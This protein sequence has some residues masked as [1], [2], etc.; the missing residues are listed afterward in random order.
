[1]ILRSA[2]LAL[3]IMALSISCVIFRPEIEI[4]LA[5][6]IPTAK[7]DFPSIIMLGDSHTSF[8]NWPIVLRCRGV[9]NFGIGGNTTAQILERLPDALAKRPRLII[10]MAG[11]NDAIQDLPEN[12]TLANLQTISAKVTQAGGKFVFVNPPPL[13]AN[14]EKIATIAQ[15]AT[16]SI[17]FTSD[18]LLSDGIHLRRSGYLKWRDAIWDVAQDNCN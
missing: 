1:M 11:T 18:D 14:P 10:L 9:A 2:G 4:W 12:E 6:K 8:V 17:P 3:A 15:G 7:P 16:I 13:P 5:M